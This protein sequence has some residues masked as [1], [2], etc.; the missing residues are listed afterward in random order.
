MMTSIKIATLAATAAVT[1][2][3]G[4]S[5]LP[6]HETEIQTE[7]MPPVEVSAQFDE[8]QTSTHATVASDAHRL[9][10]LERDARGASTQQ[11]RIERKLDDAV[12]LLKG[13]TH[14]RRGS[15][16]PTR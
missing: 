13:E 9:Q 11:R 3:F 1:F 6:R 10:K 14:D 5:V 7:A 4:A 15:G 12:R 2:A 8:G 16:Q